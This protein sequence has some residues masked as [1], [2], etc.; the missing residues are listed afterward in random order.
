MIDIKYIVVH[1]S[2]TPDEMDVTAEDIHKWH[3]DPKPDGNGWSGIGYH[4]VIRRSGDIEDGRPEYWSGAHVRGFNSCSLAVCLIGRGNFTDDQMA[5]V[6]DVITQWK[7]D[8]PNA[9][10]VGHYQLDSS[11]TCPNKPINEIWP[12]E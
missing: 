7:T 8:N 1:C 11:K 2:D 4:K 9:K 5:S 3:S 10:V 6:R 12:Y